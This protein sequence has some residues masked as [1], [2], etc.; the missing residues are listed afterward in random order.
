MLYPI[1]SVLQTYRHRLLSGMR[2][3]K[4]LTLF[5]ALSTA[6]SNKGLGLS[7]FGKEVLPTFV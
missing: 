1:L 6:P 2:R 3:Y 5:L 4:M 7:G